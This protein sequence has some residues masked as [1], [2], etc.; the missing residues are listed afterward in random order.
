MRRYL[1]EVTKKRY[2]H[3]TSSQ[4][5]QKVLKLH[6]DNIPPQPNSGE[7]QK[8]LASFCKRATLDQK[9]DMK[10]AMSKLYGS[11]QKWIQEAHPTVTEIFT[12]SPP[13]HSH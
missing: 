1:S 13:F 3:T 4:N 12:E 11:R 8:Q 5:T 2:S 10:D 9:S 6:A 7:Q